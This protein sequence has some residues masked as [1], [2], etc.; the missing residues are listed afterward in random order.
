MEPL[1]DE[2]RAMAR[3]TKKGRVTI[4]M[5]VR[6]AMAIEDG[7]ILLFEVVRSGEARMRVVKSRSLL[8]LYGALPA[9][10][11]YP[12]KEAAEQNLSRRQTLT[13]AE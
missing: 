12:G 11:A 9:T 6:K 1:E 5:G 4:P 8:D 7:D 2:I 10:R 3:V 13:D